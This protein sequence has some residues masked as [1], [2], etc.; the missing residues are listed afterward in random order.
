MD[1]DFFSIER[2]FDYPEVEE[3]V[4]YQIIIIYTV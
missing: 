2:K 3:E 1:D 4:Y